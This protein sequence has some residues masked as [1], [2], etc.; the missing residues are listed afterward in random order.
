MLVPKGEVKEK[1]QTS[2]IYVELIC[3]QDLL[4]FENLPNLSWIF[5]L[6]YLTMIFL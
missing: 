5:M 2:I 6:L 1:I 3:V 4:W